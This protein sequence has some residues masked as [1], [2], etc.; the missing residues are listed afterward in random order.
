MAIKRNTN[1]AFTPSSSG[2]GDV[3]I[4]FY[5]PTFKPEPEQTKRL[6]VKTLK[7]RSDIESLRKV[8]PFMYY[9]IF[10]YGH[11]EARIS[12]LLQENAS[13][14]GASKEV[15]RRTRLSVERDVI[16]EMFTMMNELEGTN[17]SA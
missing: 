13:G 5:F 12:S 1:K 10:E 6:D 15:K 3:E 8:D 11:D 16:V 9:S 17:C 14:T 7:R 2:R 4:D